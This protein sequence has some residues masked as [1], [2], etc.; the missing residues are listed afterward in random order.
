MIIA[1]QANMFP[2]KWRNMGYGGFWNIFASFA[3]RLDRFGE[4]EPIGGS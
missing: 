2:A 4:R 3:E 1:D